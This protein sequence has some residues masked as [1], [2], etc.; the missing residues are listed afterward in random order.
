MVLLTTKYFGLGQSGELSL[1]CR[2]QGV[3]SDGPY[4]GFI[5][6]WVINGHWT[7][8]Y[9]GTNFYIDDASYSGDRTVSHQCDLMWMGEVPFDDEDYNEAMETIRRLGWSK[10][11]TEQKLSLNDVINAQK[12][13]EHNSNMLNLADTLRMVELAEARLKEFQQVIAESFVEIDLLAGEPDG[14]KI[15]DLHVHVRKKLGV[16]I[17]AI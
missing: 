15:D 16:L 7:G 2:N 5:S 4:K 1:W 3:I 8:V 10:T 12:T 17:N 11:M 13:A 14:K 9:D 6:F